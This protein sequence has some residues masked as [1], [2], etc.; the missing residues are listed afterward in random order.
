MEKK[1]LLHDKHKRD[2]DQWKWFVFS[3]TEVNLA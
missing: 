3:T 2:F 1:A